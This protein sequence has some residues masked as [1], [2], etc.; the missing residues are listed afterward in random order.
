M[1]EYIR[2]VGGAADAAL[3]GLPSSQLVDFIQQQITVARRT[4]QQDNSA[5]IA[6]VA[7][8]EESYHAQ[9]IPKKTVRRSKTGKSRGAKLQPVPE[10]DGPSSDESDTPAPKSKK[11]RKKKKT[12]AKES[13]SAPVPEDADGDEARQP[14]AA[15]GAAR[16]RKAGPPSESDEDDNDDELSVKSL[17]SGD[18]DD[19][20]EDS[21]DVTDE[22][23]FVSRLGRR[24]QRPGR[25]RD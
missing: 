3:K 22:E 8:Y 2:K 12:A 6:E 17:G 7:A 21:S 13:A 23:E 9:Q 1:C 15:A 10:L 19:E 25:Y 18:S 16:K 14:K 4:W 11:P 20:E 5:D 24:I